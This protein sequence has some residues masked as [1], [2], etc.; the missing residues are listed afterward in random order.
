M[1]VQELLG[2]KVETT[3][4]YRELLDILTDSRDFE[5]M[6][7]KLKADVRVVFGGCDHKGV[8]ARNNIPVDDSLMH[9]CSPAVKD[10]V[11]ICVPTVEMIVCPGVMRWGNSSGTDYDR[12]TCLV[13]MDVLYS[14]PKDTAQPMPA[15]FHQPGGG[16]T[17]L[18]NA[19]GSSAEPN[20]PSDVQNSCQNA[21]LAQDMQ[22]LP[23]DT[24]YTST[25]PH[26]AAKIGVRAACAKA[27]QPH[28]DE[29]EDEL[30][31]CK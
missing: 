8:V 9:R 7:R 13:K 10:A 19:H 15:L 27:V 18:T 12:K 4:A 31:G 28:E 5:I 2:N 25:R 3:P 1:D 17:T 21:L 14:Q 23:A 26:R 16:D 6:R 11:D 24:G 22:S 20:M 30:I 29:D